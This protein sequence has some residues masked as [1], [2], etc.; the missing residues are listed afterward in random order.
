[1]AGRERFV[2]ELEGPL[3]VTSRPPKCVSTTAGVPQIAADLLQ[4]HISAALGQKQPSDFGP[5]ADTTA[6][7]LMLPQVMSV[8][9]G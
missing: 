7:N 2:F 3:R 5:S 6:A 8:A 4:H 1:M 9:S